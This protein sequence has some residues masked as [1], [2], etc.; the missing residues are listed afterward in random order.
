MSLEKYKK[1]S[2]EQKEVVNTIADSLRSAFRTGGLDTEGNPMTISDSLA[3]PDSHLALE[4]VTLEIIEESKEPNLIGHLLLDQMVSNDPS[5][6]TQVNIHMLG[7]LASEDFRVGERGEYTEVGFNVGQQN[8]ISAIYGKYGCKISIT[9]EMMQASQWNLIDQWLRKVVQAMARYKEKKIFN[10][11]IKMG[12]TVFDNVN[13]QN[14]INGRTTGRNIYG[15]GNGSMTTDNLIDMYS[16]LLTQGYTPNYIIA[17]PLQWAMFARD[18]ILREAG[19]AT[20]NI[21]Q[22]LTSKVT[23]NDPYKAIAE[24][25]SPLR[26]GNG[27]RQEMTEQERYLLDTQPPIIPVNSG[28]LNGLKILVSDLVPYDAEKRTADLIM[29]DTRN[30]GVLVTS[31]T[32]KMDSW[33]SKETDL[34]MFKLREKYAIALYDQGKAVAIAKNISLEPNEIFVNPHITL[35]NL[36]PISPK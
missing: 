17:H 5:H 31:E 29:V 32:L 6:M 16:Y 19:V 13:P 23:K 9:E 22:W 7:S 18:P 33:D 20:G 1:L 8:I 4:R 3:T 30:T 36:E 11:F 27:K 2:D 25:N 21:E 15:K 26:K 35:N 24:W 10:E 34:T 28:P 14:S 12:V